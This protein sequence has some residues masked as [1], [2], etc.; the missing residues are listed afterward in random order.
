MTFFSPNFFFFLAHL[1]FQNTTGSE[2]KRLE[3]LG[4]I[5]HTK[6]VVSFEPPLVWYPAMPRKG[7]TALIPTN[8]CWKITD[9][10]QGTITTG[11]ISCAWGFLNCP[12]SQ[13]YRYREKVVFERRFPSTVV[14]CKWKQQLLFG[15]CLCPQPQPA[16][17]LC[18][19]SWLKYLGKKSRKMGGCPLTSTN[20]GKGNWEA[21]QGDGGIRTGYG[22]TD[23][24][25]EK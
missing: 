7:C 20:P 25:V 10:S 11:N 23:F 9:P 15:A 22:W 12:P 13:L 4:D 17:A 16:E 8:S 5:H 21:A 24:G 14:V 18:S 2:L 3:D 19:R 6:F 1:W